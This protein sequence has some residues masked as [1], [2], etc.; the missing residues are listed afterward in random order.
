[1]GL[2]NC[3]DCN[4]PMSSDAT[5]CPNCNKPRLIGNTK[6]CAKCDVVYLARK[7][8]CPNCGHTNI[9]NPKSQ[10]MANQNNT[11]KWLLIL[12]LL[13]VVVAAVGYLYLNQN[14]ETIENISTEIVIPDG[15]YRLTKERTPTSTLC[16]LSAVH[17]GRTITVSG[18]KVYTTVLQEMTYDIFN[19]GGNA[20]QIG[21][22]TATCIYND[23]K[24]T[25][26]CQGEEI[27]FE[28]L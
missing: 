20:F 21:P 19:K 15:T 13:L 11:N 14:G 26:I 4:H 6:Q 18:K 22:A 10:N 23:S 1:M 27:V 7:R 3:T 28:R 24:L 17:F 9:N 25:F 16:N 2:I 12:V 8:K 5:I